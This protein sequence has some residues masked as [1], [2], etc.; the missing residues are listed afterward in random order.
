MA[1]MCQ[2]RTRRVLRLFLELTL[3]EWDAEAKTSLL[4]DG[5][6]ALLVPGSFAYPP[7]A[8]DDRICLGH[9]H[10]FGRRGDRQ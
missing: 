9:W 1:G 8:G 6:A 4:A 10:V 3:W 7:S 5:G 2:F